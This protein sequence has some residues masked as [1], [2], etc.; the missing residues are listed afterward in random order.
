M[1]A[2]Q[3]AALLAI[4]GAASI[5]L[6]YQSTSEISEFEAWQHKFGMKFSSEFE[7]TYRERV[8][9][10]NLANINAHNSKE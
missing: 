9:L 1:N 10:A 2:Q 4:I 3:I 7:R 5:L 6:G 8:F